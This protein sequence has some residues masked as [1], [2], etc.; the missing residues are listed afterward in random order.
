VTAGTQPSPRVNVDGMV[1]SVLGVQP[2]PQVRFEAPRGRVLGVV[3]ENGSER[4]TTVN[5]L[6]SIELTDGATVLLK[7]RSFNPSS[8]VDSDAG[9]IAFI[10]HGLSIFPN[11]SLAEN[12]F[13][14]HPPRRFR[15]SPFVSRRL[16]NERARE[17]LDQVNLNVSPTAL[18]GTLSIAERQLLEIARGLSI[19]AEVFIFDEP[20][21]SLNA[22]DSA[23]VIEIIHRLKENN[24]AILSVSHNLK[25]LLE[26]ADDVMVIREGRVTLQAASVNLSIGDL[27][28]AMAGGQL[29]ALYIH[30]PSRRGSVSPSM[31]EV[32]GLSKS[33]VLQNIN[34]QVGRCEIVGIAGLLGSGRSALARVLFGLDQHN[35]GS[36]RV[37]GKLLASGNM[38]ARLAAG[39]A[40][41]TDGHAQE[42]LMMDASV[43]DNMALAALSRFASRI[44]GQI[45]RPQLLDAVQRTAER[46]HLRGGDVRTTPIRSLSGDNQQKAL[47]A[48]CLLRKPKLLLLDEPTRGLDV[49]AKRE[50]YR[51][52]AD[53]AD[54]DMACL[55]ISSDL[56][57]LIGLCDRIFV[58]RQ[59]QL[60]AE[61]N[62][63]RFDREAILR[64][65]SEPGQAA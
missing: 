41:L 53:L 20:T 23:L 55:V 9:G 24:V 16:M 34:F 48:R 45:D 17:L 63:E 54:G 39:V 6:T 32:S 43:E 35:E 37:D 1:K 27:V 52:I 49:G 30:R 56:E 40:L 46:L 3:G 36:I 42:G 5:F 44:S 18:A 19:S 61:F 64:A 25:E 38:R 11:L 12:L 28:L 4:S 65:T 57:E 21:S 29:D 59:G 7:G 62:R 51:V 26:L 33:G 14:L 8:R 10:H 22:R 13:L 47:L 60:T 50:I 2:A 31:L 58:M 15:W